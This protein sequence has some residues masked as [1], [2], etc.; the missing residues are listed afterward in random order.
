VLDINK[1]TDDKMEAAGI[2]SLRTVAGYT[3]VDHKRN[4][5]ITKNRKL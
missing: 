5:D 3:V 4:E 2:S 1:R